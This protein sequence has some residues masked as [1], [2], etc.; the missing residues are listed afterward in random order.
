MLKIPMNFTGMKRSQKKTLICCSESFEKR[1]QNKTF[2]THSCSFLV[3]KENIHFNLHVKRN[4]SF[5][6]TLCIRG[7]TN[8]PYLSYL[9]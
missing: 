5:C 2:S 7:L 6:A 3:V 1:S 9:C 4:K 8:T